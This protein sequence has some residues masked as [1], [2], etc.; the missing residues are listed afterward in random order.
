[1]SFI[2]LY[3]VGVLTP[4][5][6]FQNLSLTI[7]EGCRM[8][9][10]AGNGGGKTTLLR[11]IAGLAEPTEGEITCSRG[12]RLGFVEQD[13]PAALHDQTLY[14]CLRSALP[15]NQQS[16]TW[17]VDVLLAS[18]AFPQE[19]YHLPIRAL[20][21]GWQKLA[22]I[23]RAFV[24]EP[25]ALLLD[26]P[27]NHLD[28][29][30]IQFLESWLKENASR[31][32][33]VIVSHDRQFLEAC[34]TH[35][36]FLRPKESKLYG[37]S[38]GAARKLL[39]ADDEAREVRLEQDKKNANRLRAQASE[40]KNI[41]INSGSDLALK[42]AKQLRQRASNIESTFKELDKERTAEIKLRSRE[43]H[44]RVL[45][46]I[47][48]VVVRTPDGKALFNTG[49]FKIFQGDRIVLLGANGAGKSQLIRRIYR[50]LLDPEGTP[51]VR[52][53]PSIVVGYADQHMSQ[54]PDHET[55]FEVITNRF[56]LGDQRSRTLL[57]GAGFPV[58]RQN[59][60]VRA[61]SLG[62]KA[63]L[64]MLVLRLTEPNFYLL[65]EPTN[66]VDIV[67]QEKLEAEILA[68]NAT[69]LLVSHD[70]SF[71]G[72]IG[73]RFIRIENAKLIESV[74]DG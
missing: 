33:M 38:Y 69:C 44:S 57:A 1:M 8:G 32:P 71:V 36:L 24:A 25:D 15:S 73:T 42:K 65:D 41:G 51:D 50:A 43:I 64:G 53:R 13:V 3:Q 22:L 46:S 14:E 20:S 9:V 23:A 52:V 70:R 56:H 66:H 40:L 55:P 39:S 35:T 37:C 61:F 74:A 47:E 49:N 68:Q 59:D 26:E 54:L 19:L 67:G 16:E 63:R 58:G 4:E 12:M 29:S 45:L 21:G 7:N 27:T 18:F 31:L 60:P 2:T 17:R 30:K 28:L 34:T 11:C 62:Q 6:L 5:P 48:G 72:A 10:V